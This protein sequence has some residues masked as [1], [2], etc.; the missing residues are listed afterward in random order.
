MHRPRLTLLF[1]VFTLLTVVVT[2]PLAAHLWDQVVDVSIFGPVG[3]MWRQDVFLTMW[4]LAW[5]THALCTDP[6]QLWHANALRPMAMPLAG[7][8]HMLGYQWL[9]AP[10]YVTTNNPVFAQQAIVFLTFVL[11]GVTMALLVHE[12][13]D[14]E[15]AAWVAGCALAF[16]PWRF[17]ELSRVQML[18]T[19]YV[20]LVVLYLA[21]YL[22][23]GSWRTLAAMGVCLVLQTLTS[24]YLG[25]FAF[26]TVGVL[27]LPSLLAG[28][29]TWR[30]GVALALAL[31]CAAVVL[32]PVGLPYARLRA[33]GVIPADP[34]ADPSVLAFFL[35][36]RPWFSVPSSLGGVLIGLAAVG[37]GRLQREIWPGRAALLTLAAAGYVL[38][39]GPAL[40]IGGRLIPLPYRILGWCVPGLSAVRYPM[41]FSLLTVFAVTLLAGRGVAF[42]AQRFNRRGYGV[43]AVGFAVLAAIA[44]LV[45]ARSFPGGRIAL[46]PVAVADAVPPVYGWLREH[47][48]GGTVVE[49][50]VGDDTFKGYYREAVYMYFSTYDWLPLVNGFTG[51]AVPESIAARASARALPDSAALQTLRTTTNLRWVVLHQAQL[52]AAAQAAWRAAEPQWH[53]VAQFGSDVVFDVASP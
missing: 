9:F 28:S 6:T 53:P 50:P 3:A 43:P 34:Y 13:T 46:V 18:G 37:C 16:C 23:S 22:R 31:G 30:Q 45:D 42:V 38:S 40:P 52:D 33:A 27:L 15:P 7:S 35:S 25:Y 20:P 47:G 21:R 14:S 2:W 24:F 26:A 12:V 32:I 17:G 11:T 10:L 39:L 1:I 19:F 41:R 49:V 8:E 29:L 5:G 36:A 48:D 44:V 51:Y 4:I